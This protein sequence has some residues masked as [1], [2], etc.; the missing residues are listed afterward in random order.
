MASSTVK[1][2]DHLVSNV[3]YKLISFE[4]T[5]STLRYVVSTAIDQFQFHFSLGIWVIYFTACHQVWKTTEYHESEITPVYTCIATCRI[6][7]SG[8]R[9]LYR[10]PDISRWSIL[11]PEHRDIMD[12]QCINFPCSHHPV[13]APF[14]VRRLLSL[15]WNVIIRIIGYVFHGCMVKSQYCLISLCAYAYNQASVT[16]FWSHKLSMKFV[17]P[18]V[19]HDALKV[20]FFSILG[21]T[22]E[23]IK[24]LVNS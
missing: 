17:K 1:F 8:C 15:W 19:Q 13:M 14:L 23:R 6:V 16:C 20:F 24:F 10:N 4:M 11:D 3:V 22:Y 12:L 21:D 5:C 9:D 7:N 2:D 18:T